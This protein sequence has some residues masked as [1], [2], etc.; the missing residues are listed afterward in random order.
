[1]FVKGNI[2]GLLTMQVENLQVISHFK[3]KYLYFE[4]RPRRWNRFRACLP[5]V[6]GVTRLSI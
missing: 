2:E 6:G 5:R 4:L 3:T 1:M